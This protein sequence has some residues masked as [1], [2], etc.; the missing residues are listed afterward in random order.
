MVP[1][2]SLSWQLPVCGRVGQTA[3]VV[4]SL[5]GHSRRTTGSQ[6]AKYSHNALRGCGSCLRMQAYKKEGRV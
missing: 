3:K 5:S 1:C 6:L 2:C 4:E